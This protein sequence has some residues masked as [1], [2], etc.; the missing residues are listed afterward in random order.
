MTTATTHK[1]IE[2][3]YAGRKFRSRLEARWAVVFDALGLKWEYEKEGYDLDGVRYLPDFYI[4]NGGGY[5]IEI[6]PDAPDETEIKKA[7]LLASHTRQW[8][9]ILIGSP[10]LGEFEVLAFRD[11]HP[12]GELAWHVE[13][14]IELCHGYVLRNLVNTWPGV[15]WR[16]VAT[17]WNT[18]WPGEEWGDIRTSGT[19]ELPYAQFKR[20]L[21]ICPQCK[22]LEFSWAARSFD[23]LEWVDCGTLEFGHEIILKRHVR[24]EVPEMMR[25]CEECEIE[26]EPMHPF[27]VDALQRGLSA[28]FEHGETPTPGRIISTTANYHQP[29]SAHETPRGKAAMQT[30]GVENFD[31]ED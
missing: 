3:Q 10:R 26:A 21:S 11:R 27:L 24:Q 7:G 8:V 9:N 12:S 18:R 30:F 16:D 5:W 15:Y 14:A 28:R 17:A 31:K 13:Q 23:N 1:A 4:S 2:T 19:L 20:V 6:K 29:L 25:W 22:G